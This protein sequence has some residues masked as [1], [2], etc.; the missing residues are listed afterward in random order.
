MRKFIAL[1]GFICLHLSLSAQLPKD[2]GR[3]VKRMDPVANQTVVTLYD[4]PN[5]LGAFK[6]LGPGQYVLSDFNDVT[7]SI[8]V[9]AGMVAYLYEHASPTQGYGQGVDLLEDNVNLAAIN[10]DNKASYITIF[11]ATRDAN[12]VWVRNYIRDGVFVSGHWERKRANPGAPNTVAVVSP[13]IEGPVPTSPSVLAVNGATT[14]ISS[15]GIQPVEGKLLWERAVNNQLRVIGNDYRGIEEIGSACFERASNNIAIPDNINFWYPQKQRNDNRSVVYFKRTLVGLIQYADNFIKSGTYEDYDMNIDIAPDPPFMYLLTDAHK[16][17]HTALMKTQYYGS[18]GKSGDGECPDKFET[19]EAEI[20]DRRSPSSGYQSKLVQMSRNR[21]G[22]KLAVYGVWLYDMGHCC[23]PEIHPAEQ[24]WWNEPEGSARKFNFSVFCDASARYWWRSQ[25][26]DGT[27]I[28]PWAEPPIKGLFAIAFEYPLPASNLGSVNYPT[29][30]FEVANLE[31][32]NVIEYPNADQVYNL[33]YDG[34]KI[35]SFVP[36]NNAFK[37]S[38][39]HVGI[40][41]DNKNMIRG[42]LVIETSVGKTTQIATELRFPGVPASIK[43]PMGT[44]PSQVPEAYEK[45]FFK[46]EAGHYYFTVTEKTIDNSP[47]L[48]LRNN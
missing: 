36:H 40:S 7:S 27:K 46:K 15:L 47:T 37:V 35:V 31:H 4:E 14:T 32:S 3:V 2:R 30:Q 10:F 22:Q 42:F 5:Y 21:Y 48:M 12:Y 41:P 9:P 39:E 19:L 29:K 16:P 28:R 6:T 18:F 26:D 1:L 20:S 38:F 34:K 8:K 45:N 25:M 23:H 13:P 43:F 11:S 17:E 44:L 24:A 33:V